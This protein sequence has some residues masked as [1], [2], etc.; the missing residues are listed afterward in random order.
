MVCPRHNQWFFSF[1]F[2]QITFVGIY[3]PTDQGVSVEVHNYLMTN[4]AA[5]LAMLAAVGLKMEKWIVQMG[6]PMILTKNVE[7]N[8]QYQQRIMWPF[9]LLSWTIMN[10]PKAMHFPRFQVELLDLR[11]LRS[12][13]IMVKLAD[14]VLVLLNSNSA[15]PNSKL[16]KLFSSYFI[17]T[18]VIIDDIEKQRMKI[19]EQNLP[20]RY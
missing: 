13:V 8:V 5:F 16:S 3:V 19:L 10:A 17:T 20:N 15:I 1:H 7:M 12:I 11:I 18:N 2:L 4:S 6:L 14:Q 9:L